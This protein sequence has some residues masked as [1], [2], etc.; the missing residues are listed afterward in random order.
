MSLEDGI[1]QLVEAEP[2]AF[3]A[4]R[5]CRLECTA[6]RV[7]LTVEGQAG[8]FLIA[9][10]DR[11]HIESDGLALVEGMPSGAIRFISDAPWPEPRSISADRPHLPRPMPARLREVVTSLILALLKS[12]R[13]S[14]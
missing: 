8:D 3:R 10:G 1:V 2:L 11:V 13:F 14:S 12:R 7:W 9:Q 5:N 6:G 4:A